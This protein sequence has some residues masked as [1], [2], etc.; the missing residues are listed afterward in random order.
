MEP[1]IIRNGDAVFGLAGI[2]LLGIVV[3]AF[4]WNVMLCFWCLCAMAT[5]ALV[6]IPGLRSK[7]SYI[8]VVLAL[9]IFLLSVIY[10][11][12]K[13]QSAVVKNTTTT[14]NPLFTRAIAIFNAYLPYRQASLLGGIISGSTAALAPDVKTA[15]TR[16]GTSYIV[17][18][19]GYKIYLLAEMVREV[20]KRFLP[21]TITSLCALFAIG[22]FVAVANAPISALRAGVM[23]G[24]VALAEACGRKFNA[25]IAL[26][27]TAALMT[28]FDP[29]LLQSGG[30]LLSFM[31]L[32]GI[33]ALGPLFKKLLKIE[34]GGTGIFGWKGHLVMTFAVNLAIFPVVYMLYGDLPIVSFASN[35][36]IAIPFGMTIALGVALAVL[37][38]IF[39][40]A[41]TIVAPALNFLLSCQLWIIDIFASFA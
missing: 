27:A 11:H 8:L 21:R 3:A 41:V 12:L 19:Y 40:P 29:S 35:F 22:S 25:R 28:I 32:V 38:G 9:C 16:S 23:A 26:M 7:P 6:S 5:I 31:S 17:G 36:F 2:F 20:G 34:R 37:G 24:I 13:V 14:I 33:Y 15:M 30:F 4:G 10:F 39:S 18:M 1:Y